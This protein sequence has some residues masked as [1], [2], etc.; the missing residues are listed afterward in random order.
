ML[1]LDPR[2]CR[3]QFAYN[4]INKKLISLVVVFT[5]VELANW[6]ISANFHPWLA[7]LFVS[8]PPIFTCSK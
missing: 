5:E 4:S 1:T 7:F 6:I 8:Y 3:Q 2:V